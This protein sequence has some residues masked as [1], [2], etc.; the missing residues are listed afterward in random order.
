[1]VGALGLEG[2]LLEHCIYFYIQ[3]EEKLSSFIEVN[4]FFCEERVLVETLE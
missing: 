3:N 4:F 2:A 1:M